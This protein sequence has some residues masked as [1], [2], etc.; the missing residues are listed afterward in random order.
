M[1]TLGAKNI[2]ALSRSGLVSDEAQALA[3][4]L[5][6]AGVRFSVYT[7]NVGDRTTLEQVFDTCKEMPPFVG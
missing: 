5:E 7:C 4:E 3:K 6:E 2:I 1:V